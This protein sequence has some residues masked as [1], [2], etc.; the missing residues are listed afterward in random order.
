MQD[1]VRTHMQSTWSPSDRM[2]MSRLFRHLVELLLMQ[3]NSVG[4][5]D[6]DAWLGELFDW[7]DGS[8]CLDDFDKALLWEDLR[9]IPPPRNGPLRVPPGA[10]ERLAEGHWMW[11]T[12]EMRSAP[13]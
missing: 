12:T 1:A 11:L 8:H 7:L 4:V 3:G 5:S 6:W 9:R 13:L 2:R 10:A